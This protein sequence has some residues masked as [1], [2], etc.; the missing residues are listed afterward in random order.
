MLCPLLMVTVI[1][2][3]LASASQ[4]PISIGTKRSPSLD[5]LE[6]RLGME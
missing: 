1:P 5:T 2:S 4:F 6:E 3:E